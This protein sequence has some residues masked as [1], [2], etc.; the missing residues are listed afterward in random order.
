MKSLAVYVHIPFCHSRCLYCDFYLELTKY[1]QLE[2]F[3]RALLQEVTSRWGLLKGNLPPVHSVYVGGGTPSVLPASFY[4]ELLNTF[5][6][7]TELLPDAELTFEANPEDWASPPVAYREAGF[8]RVSL[9]VQ[10]LDPTVLKRLSRRHTP[11]LAVEAVE[12]C[13]LAGFERISLDLMMG[14]PGQTLTSWQETL[15]TACNLPI[16]HIS[17]YG[18]QLE[19]GTPLHTLVRRQVKNYQL[20]S[21]DTAADLYSWTQGFLAQQG[22]AQYEISNWAKPGQQSRHNLTYWQNLPYWAFGPA[23]HG[24]V[25]PVRYA[26]QASLSGYLENPLKAEF[27]PVSLTE[28]LENAVI[29]GLR[30]SEG[31][32][33]EDF[34]R[35]YGVALLEMFKTPINKLL[36]EGYLQLSESTLTLKPEFYSVSNPIL[37]QFLGEAKL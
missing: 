8:N 3:Q 23:A 9:G 22:F 27:E 33:L 12:A 20:P 25:H 30:T 14:L 17:A 28:R 2:A 24:Y 29:F 31:L 7:F 10:S 5:K 35:R 37:Q 1:G 15:S 13:Q 11:E 6:Q 4:A 32:N 19:E 26:N 18:L 36:A 16:Q 21:E 34:K